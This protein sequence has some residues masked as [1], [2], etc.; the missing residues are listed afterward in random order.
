MDIHSKIRVLLIEDNPADARLLKEMLFGVPDQPFQVEWVTRLSQALE[1]LSLSV[2]AVI[3]LDLSLPDSKGFDTFERVHAKVATIPIV[4]LTGLDDE[5]FAL[6]S[7]RRGAQDYLVK[8]QLDS[9]LI[10]KVL[11]YAIEREQI[12]E[13]L[14]HMTQELERSNKEL[15]HFAYV[16]SHDLQEPLRMVA[17]YA[18]L[19][20]KNY[21]GKL[22][23]DADDF[24]RYMLEGTDQM[25]QLIHDLLAY[26][27]V[28]TRGKEFQSTSFE[29]VLKRVTNNLQLIIEETKASVTFGPLP[30]IM[31]DDL[32]IAQLF[33]NLINNAIKF[34]GSEA[35]KI[36]VSASKNSGDWVFCV[37][38]NGI[39][40]DPQYLENIFVIFQRL[41]NRA[42]YPGTGIGLAICK[43]IVDRH[44]GKIWAQSELGK[45]SKFYF[46][47]PD[48]RG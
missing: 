16:A 44:Q 26:A 36:H 13:R 40:I 10:S 18:Q 11:R 31:A 27:R 12:E 5:V 39:G 33:Q 14:R 35:P 19:L 15:E 30:E 7:I 29:Q 28:G 3:L 24:I 22:N 25:K 32:Q 45:G 46:S 34:H 17:S 42:E 37:S 6:E 20:A 9:K 8:G 48:R 4:V 41:H 23:Q 38:D 2:P 43:K 21:K 47:L 1:H